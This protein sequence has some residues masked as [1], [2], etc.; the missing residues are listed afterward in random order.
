MILLKDDI[1]VDAQELVLVTS[2]RDERVM[3][4]EL[5]LPSGAGVT[6]MNT[7]APNPAADTKVF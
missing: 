3:R 7:H 2:P 6:I 1:R 4:L 5:L